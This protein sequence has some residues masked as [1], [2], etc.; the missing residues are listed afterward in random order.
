[1]LKGFERETRVLEMYFLSYFFSYIFYNITCVLKI[2]ILVGRGRVLKKVLFFA[3]L[4]FT[5]T[6]QN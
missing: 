4:K 6:K 3:A 5:F 2:N 1:M